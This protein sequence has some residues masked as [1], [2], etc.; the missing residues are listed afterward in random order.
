[1]KI[2]IA[3]VLMTCA[4]FPSPSAAQRGGVA[5]GGLGGA[6]FSGS[7][8]VRPIA[9]IALR[10][11]GFPSRRGFPASQFGAYPLSGASSSG[12]STDAG[13]WGQSENCGDRYQAPP[14]VVAAQPEPPPPPP[15]PPVQPVIHEYNWPKSSDSVAGEFSLVMKDGTVHLA[16]AVWVQDNEVRYFTR[17]GDP[18]HVSANLIDRE[19]SRRRNV[20][21]GLSLWLPAGKPARESRP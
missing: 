5:G 18:E 3:S 14:S 9:P 19:A 11:A 15:P 12:F 8:G 13:C 6:R 2:S 16:T 1:M 17:D 20:E 7:P 4:L 21:K 10:R